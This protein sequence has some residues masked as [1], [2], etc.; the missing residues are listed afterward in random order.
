[1]FS[2]NGF[3]IFPEASR[4]YP[5]GCNYYWYDHTFQVPHFLY[6]YINSCIYY[7]YYYYY[8]LRFEK[9]LLLA[10]FGLN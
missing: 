4:Y 3:Q 2:W 10:Y 6:L 8:Y 5:S 7:Y 1:M 9:N